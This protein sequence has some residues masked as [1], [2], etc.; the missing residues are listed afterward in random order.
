MDILVLA[1]IFFDILR[2]GKWVFVGTWQAQECRYVLRV[3][4]MTHLVFLGHHFLC[5]FYS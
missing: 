1:C 4:I 3:G 2:Y 5:I